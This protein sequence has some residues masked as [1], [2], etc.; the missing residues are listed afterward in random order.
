MK[1]DKWD[2]EVLTSMTALEVKKIMEGK[3]GT[4]VSEQR[5]IFCGKELKNEET[6]S[7]HSIENGTAIFMF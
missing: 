4:P 2:I 6:L 7:E 1:G 5:L 3:S